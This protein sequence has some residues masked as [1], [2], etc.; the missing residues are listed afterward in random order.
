MHRIILQTL[1]RYKH[2][3]QLLALFFEPLLQPGRAPLEPH[4]PAQPNAGDAVILRCALPGVIPNPRFG[5]SPAGR[6]LCRINQLRGTIPA[7]WGHLRDI[8]CFR[9]HSFSHLELYCGYGNR[10]SKFARSAD[11]QSGAVWC[12]FPLSPSKRLIS[13]PSVQ[14][15]VSVPLPAFSLQNSPLVV[16]AFHRHVAPACKPQ[17]N[18]CA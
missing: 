6:Q 9:R 14:P 17:Q 12:E 5:H 16:A 4:I 8:C 2:K 3:M 7:P 13:F 11:S 15:I 18:P 10:E 1:A